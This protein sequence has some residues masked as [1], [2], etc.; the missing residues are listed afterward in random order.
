VRPWNKIC[1][2]TL[3]YDDGRWRS[4]LC[5]FAICCH[6]ALA[7]AIL[8]VSRH[9]LVILASWEA[10]RK[11][12]FVPARYSGRLLAAS[13]AD[14]RR[15][16]RVQR[17]P[18]AKAWSGLRVRA[19]IAAISRHSYSRRLDN[20]ALVPARHFRPTSR[21]FLSSSRRPSCPIVLRNVP[22]RLRS[23]PRLSAPCR[24]IHY[25]RC[26]PFHGRWGC[27]RAG[28]KSCHLS[29]SSCCREPERFGLYDHLLAQASFC[30]LLTATAIPRQ[31]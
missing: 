30:C 2:F 18:A 12:I 9:S 28:N 15:M 25:R 4:S 19:G 5:Y 3:Y 14:D 16:C 17:D 6:F 31:A 21:L 24:S 20:V 26:R 11:S 22:A 27:A 7:S 13:T 23:F 10:A 29:A 1:N 8:D